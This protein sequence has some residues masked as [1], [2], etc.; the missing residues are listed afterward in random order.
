MAKECWKAR[1]CGK[2]GR[3]SILKWTQ[4]LIIKYIISLLIEINP[5]FWAGDGHGNGN[6]SCPS[7][8]FILS[9]SAFSKVV[10][11]KPDHLV[12]IAWSGC[13]DTSGSERGMC[14]LLECFGGLGRKWQHLW[15][16]IL[17][18]TSPDALFM[19]EAWGTCFPDTVYH[20][21]T[22]VDLSGTFPRKG[23]QT[24]SVLAWKKGWLWTFVWKAEMWHV[25]D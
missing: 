18:F 5:P 8:L 3:P 17:G 1:D 2:R 20:C 10:W 15:H 12:E 13:C 22:I 7:D 25:Y 9:F 24:N 4:Y 6:F 19:T 21:L 16:V 11:D 23:R 14:W